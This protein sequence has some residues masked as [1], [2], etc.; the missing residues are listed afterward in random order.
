MSDSDSAEVNI[1]AWVGGAI[2][3]VVAVALI[4]WLIRYSL[5]D[6]ILVRYNVL[7]LL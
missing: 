5:I 7:T 4:L 3:I 6:I 1:G 2:G